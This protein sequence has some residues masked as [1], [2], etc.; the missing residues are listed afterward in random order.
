MSH[1]LAYKFGSLP[2]FF[3]SAA[4][5]TAACG[6]TEAETASDELLNFVREAKAGSAGA[7]SELIVRYQRRIAGFVYT[8]TGRRD[9]VED[10]SQRILIKMVR[11]I[12]SLR[13]A[14]Q[15][16]AWL[17]T[18]A[19]HICIDQLRRD[20]LHRVFVPFGAEHT[21]LPEPPGAVNAE[22]LDALRHALSQ[23]SP[24]ERLLVALMQEGRAY[25]EI[26]NIL[27]INVVAVKA[28]VHRVR[29][30]LREYYEVRG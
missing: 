30:R 17:F 18:L 29:L 21:E 12:G 6:R 26:A 19:R 11:S 22:E 13:S 24:K 23:L 4:T 20:K 14:S 3:R 1:S 27:S 15:F 2:V 25:R 8:V 9:H 16:E 5:P 7:Q 28:R 10:L